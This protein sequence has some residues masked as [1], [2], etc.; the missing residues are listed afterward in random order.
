MG[1]YAAGEM[2]YFDTEGV[3]LGLSAPT[4]NMAGLELN[5]NIGTAN[6]LVCPTVG[7]AINQ[8]IGRK[9]KL[10]KI[11]VH[12]TIK[13]AVQANITAGEEPAAIRLCLVHDSQT[14]GTATASEDVFQNPTTTDSNAVVNAFMS[15]ATLGRFKILKEKRV[16]L[17]DPNL[18]FDGTNIESNARIRW[19]KM[20]YKFKKPLVIDFNATNGG[21]IAD[22]VNHQFT[23]MGWTTS[24]NL[25]PEVNYLARA[26]YKE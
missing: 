7:S 5:P 19:F 14:N 12:G 2:K 3:D 8:R 26:Y 24:T 22:V 16:V 18:A 25:N 17:E 11:R 13:T 21:T 1:V 4:T 9:I 20:D 10:H 15:L 6:T 23:L